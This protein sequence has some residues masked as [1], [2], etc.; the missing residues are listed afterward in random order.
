MSN[1][2]SP[3]VS[4]PTELICIE[5][6]NWRVLRSGTVYIQPTGNGKVR[7]HS[8]RTEQDRQ[9]LQISVK[10]QSYSIIV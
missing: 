1:L 2:V 9:G 5:K 6:G 3:K 4:T 8:L 7:Y 10:E